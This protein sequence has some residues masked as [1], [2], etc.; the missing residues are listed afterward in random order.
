MLL[1]V[2]GELHVVAG[3]DLEADGGIELCCITG[4]GI[5]LCSESVDLNDSLRN[6]FT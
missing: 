1:L 6:C 5:K 3:W 4:Y 2:I